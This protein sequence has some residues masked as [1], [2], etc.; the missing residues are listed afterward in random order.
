M[1][2]TPLLMLCRKRALQCIIGIQSIS[3]IFFSF[4]P[5]YLSYNKTKLYFQLGCGKFTIKSL[6]RVKLA[7][8]YTSLKAAA[9]HKNS[10]CVLQMCSS[11]LTWFVITTGPSNP[12]CFQHMQ[13]KKKPIANKTSSIFLQFVLRTSW[14]SLDYVLSFVARGFTF[15]N[16]S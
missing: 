7:W 15:L 1:L 9:G 3:P 14:S 8:N 6:T 5:W 10:V 12:L 2:N 11:P 16:L 4:F 13:K